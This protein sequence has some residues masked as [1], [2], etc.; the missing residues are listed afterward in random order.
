MSDLGD[1]GVHIFSIGDIGY[2]LHARGSSHSP[3]R[4]SLHD[5][6]P[7]ADGNGDGDKET[8]VM[9]MYSMY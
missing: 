9:G 4:Y 6:R 3:L 5:C 7:D 1:H 8:D 2:R